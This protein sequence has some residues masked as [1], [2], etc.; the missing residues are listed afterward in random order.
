M[1]CI[2]FAKAG[3]TAVLQFTV[4]EPGEY[5]IFCSIEDTRKQE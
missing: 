5:E 2:F 3:E 1:I 4:M